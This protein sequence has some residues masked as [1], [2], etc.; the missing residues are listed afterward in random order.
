MMGGHFGHDEPTATLRRRS[1]PPSPTW[2]GLEHAPE[3]VG[4]G[5]TFRA[6]PPLTAMTLQG[7]L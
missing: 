4:L 5:R 1:R 3:R 7:L 6:K 2:E